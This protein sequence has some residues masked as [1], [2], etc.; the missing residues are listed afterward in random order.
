MNTNQQSQHLT[1]HQKNALHAVTSALT[2]E[3]LRRRLAVRPSTLERWLQNDFFCTELIRHIGMVQKIS[4]LLL[5]HSL[6]DAAVRLNNL[7]YTASP[8][9]CRKACNDI[10][11]LS[12]DREE[13][14]LRQTQQPK[15]PPVAVTDPVECARLYKLYRPAIQTD[16]AQYLA[17]AEA[18]PHACP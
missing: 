13:T 11:K 5:A 12:A 1:R 4:G 8:E 16:D 6:P 3:D 2:V 17:A 14:K 15:S 7:L 18:G 10:F 9:T